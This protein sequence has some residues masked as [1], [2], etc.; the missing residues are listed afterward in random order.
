M[1]TLSFESTVTLDASQYEAMPLR[2]WCWV[3]QVARVVSCGGPCGAVAAMPS[4]AA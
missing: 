2:R 4:S 3:S 1:M